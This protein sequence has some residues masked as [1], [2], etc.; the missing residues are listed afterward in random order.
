M[1]YLSLF[2][3]LLLWAV[4]GRAQHDR[5]W[6]SIEAI[7]KDAKG[8]VGVALEPV[9]AVSDAGIGAGANRGARTGFN[10]QRHFPMQ[11]VFKF[12]L[13]MY[14]LDQVDKGK[15]SLDQKIHILKKDWIPGMWSPMRDH[16]KSGDV[17]VAL[18]EIL[19]YTVSNSDNNG[20][21]LLFR[22]AG[23]PDQVHAYIR[24][25]GID[26]IWI[27]ATEAEMA[28][29]W[30]VQ[31]R[32]WATPAAMAALL[33][34]FYSGKV[35]SAASTRWLL[36]RMTETTTGPK[37]IK[38]LLPSGVVVAHKTGTS[39]TND[40]GITAATNDVGII[41]LPDGR[42]L[43]I[44]VFVSDAKADEATRERVIARIAKVA[45]D[46]MD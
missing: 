41:T 12:P 29:S 31:Y 44:V 26:G 18:R 2:F 33:K 9:E 16:Y 4:A 5:P 1:K 19:T 36:Q 15:L 13:A 7:A 45:Y 35:L 42:H 21:D 11:S 46:I 39:N 10:D 38:G 24:E 30:E 34:L 22:L 14:I 37:R 27:L 3:F 32:N 43:I 6:D 8:I 28:R 25:L 23:G 20:C 40:A 17:R